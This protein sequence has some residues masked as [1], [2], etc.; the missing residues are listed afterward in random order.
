MTTFRDDKGVPGGWG[1]YFAA[2]NGLSL[3]MQSGKYRNY[4]EVLAAVN[5]LS[6]TTDSKYTALAALITEHINNQN[7]ID[8]KLSSLDIDK[9]LVDNFGTATVSQ[10]D[11]NDL[12]TTPANAA[13]YID[14]IP[15][16]KTTDTI[17]KQ[18]LNPISTYGD[19]TWLPV[20]V[21]NDY[22]GATSVSA[23][24]PEVNMV[25]DNSTYM[26]IHAGTNGV[27]RGLYFHRLV[28]VIRRDDT[29]AVM[30]MH[31]KYTP[32]GLTVG[33]ATSVISTDGNCIVG[34]ITDG[35][36][37]GFVAIVNGDMNPAL[38]KTSFITLPFDESRDVFST[39]CVAGD[40]V[41]VFCG[42][43]TTSGNKTHEV[44][45][46]YEFLVYRIQISTMVDGGSATVEQ[47]TGW[48]VIGFHDVYN[49]DG[50]RLADCLV[51]ADVA[52]NPLMVHRGTSWLNM[53]DPL[54]CNM[55]IHAEVNPDNADEI[56]LGIHH[57]AKATTISGE[58]AYGFMAYSVLLTVG[59]TFAATLEED[60]AG[61]LVVNSGV[62][63]AIVLSSDSMVSPHNVTGVG[64]FA[65]WANTCMSRA[66]YVLTRYNDL[67]KNGNATY[68]KSA[69]VGF[70][71][72]F[73]A[74]RYKTLSLHTEVTSTIAVDTETDFTTNMVNPRSLPGNYVMMNGQ[75]RSYANQGSYSRA[76]RVTIT[77]TPTVSYP[78]VNSGN[79]LGWTNSLGTSDYNVNRV[80]NQCI[81]ISRT[82]AA[83]TTVVTNASVMYR[84]GKGGG[85]SID[86]DGVISGT[87]VYDVNEIENVVY[88]ALSLITTR[89]DIF[90]YDW[91]AYVPQDAAL[92]IAVVA[93]YTLPNG[94]GY[95]GGHVL[96]ELEHSG[97]RADTFTGYTYKKLCK[98]VTYGNT[99]KDVWLDVESMG[100]CHHY[101]TT[102]SDQ[103]SAIGCP[104]VI[105]GLSND[106][107]IIGQRRDI[108]I[109]FLAAV[110]STNMG[111]YENETIR[112][113]THD[114][115]PGGATPSGI[116]NST[117]GLGLVNY[118]VNN[119]NYNTL[120]LVN[121][122]AFTYAQFVT[123]NVI[124]SYVMNA[125]KKTTTNTFKFYCDEPVF[126]AGRSYTVAKRILSLSSVTSTPNGKVFYVGLLLDGGVVGYDLSLTAQDSSVYYMAL[127][128]IA[129]SSA[130]VLTFDLRK[131]IRVSNY[132]MQTYRHGS[133]IPHTVGSAADVGKFHWL[134]E[135]FNG[136]TF[137]YYD[138]NGTA[139]SS[140]DTT[141]NIAYIMMNYD[142][143]AAIS[144][145][146]VTIEE[147]TGSDDDYFL[148]KL[149]GTAWAAK[150]IKYVSNS[151][152][153]NG[154]TRIN[155]SV[156]DN[157]ATARRLTTKLKVTITF[158][159]VQ[160]ITHT[161]TL[162]YTL[163]AKTG[164]MTK[165]IAS[166]TLQ[167]NAAARI[168]FG[169]GGNGFAWNLAPIQHGG[170][171][172]PTGSAPRGISINMPLPYDNPQEVTVTT[173]LNDDPDNPSQYLFQRAGYAS[174]SNV[175]SCAL[176]MDVG[177]NIYA[178]VIT[179][180]PANGLPWFN[181]AGPII[182]LTNAGSTAEDFRLL[183]GNMIGV[184]PIASTRALDTWTL[185]HTPPWYYDDQRIF[186]FGM[187]IDASGYFDIDFK[188]GAVT[189]AVNNDR[190][191][192]TTNVVYYPSGEVWT[193]GIRGTGWED[194][195]HY[196]TAT[197]IYPDLAFANVTTIPDLSIRLGETRGRNHCY[198]QRQP[199]PANNYVARVWLYDYDDSS[200]FYS[201]NVYLTATNREY[202]G[203]LRYVGVSLLS[204]VKGPVV[205]HP[206]DSVWNLKF[207]NNSTKNI[208]NMSVEIMLSPSTPADLSNLTF[209]TNRAPAGSDTVYSV[210]TT[211]TVTVSVNA[212]ATV[213]VPVEVYGNSVVV[214]G[215]ERYSEYDVNAYMSATM[216]YLGEQVVAATDDYHVE[217]YD[218][219]THTEVL[220]VNASIVDG[221]TTSWTFNVFNDKVNIDSAV[222]TYTYAISP[223][224]SPNNTL[225][226]SQN[227][228]GAGIGQTWYEV[229]QS[230]NVTAS[231]IDADG[232]DQTIRLYGNG[233]GAVS[234]GP[235]IYEPYAYNGSVV[236]S[237]SITIDGKTK[238]FDNL[239]VITVDTTD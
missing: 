96:F 152:P 63:T 181:N 221:A 146:T 166:G 71:T 150:T 201:T 12:F 114:C 20:N 161:D 226:F 24:S 89:S 165:H 134:S 72:K 16:F 105:R 186:S 77:G 220:M 11:I 169:G 149:P 39:A 239:G 131:P 136:I 222:I 29:T 59:D 183:V 175:T 145:V 22:A 47:V 191:G 174:V 185:E 162:G 43:V 108:G 3:M 27:T 198:V 40:Y 231:N 210:V 2:V 75:G 106:P 172:F 119:A 171:G 1:E 36:T 232:V 167:P 30:N 142:L 64:K 156:Y 211:K 203:A 102:E 15:E 129:V 82:S 193:P 132:E 110:R 177:T 69:I 206:N 56:R 120:M 21:T 6:T 158:G 49:G 153:V 184:T 44:T 138:T 176:N 112:T 127:G 19:K 41:Y 147:H 88:N 230:I 214:D 91:V 128:T 148:F 130:G 194:Y 66:G 208:T 81:F 26:G 38:H 121:S 116:A 55:R 109:I 94:N 154:S 144:N 97:S 23:H 223:D 34:R 87:F 126:M 9:G 235:V 46:P 42:P 101:L 189:I 229:Q 157:F 180:N 7:N 234:G 202:A 76:K 61:H 14:T 139:H 151:I 92:P 124:N 54:N 79:L 196:V 73:A 60:G 13:T 199:T 173:P 115:Y 159:G 50:I 133:G 170:D 113:L 188:T 107:S 225:T 178:K 8:H 32:K 74:L 100:G 68:A 197:K 78:T 218:P 164:A 48:D 217:Y 51:S 200:A 233:Q 90:Q 67:I 70:T 58:E 33:N 62:A 17:H 53:L 52:N 228:T 187:A 224:T 85:I 25:E 37:N 83:N 190:R 123:G 236:M 182:E 95:S 192:Y 18:G 31:H 28:D 219:L 117:I 45:T 212:G 215:V 213:I 227:T 104:V 209:S 237:A 205:I 204:I 195:G 57:T 103:L 80:F 10:T 155:V 122:M 168:K 143:N 118:T 4:E 207:V 163:T 238:V 179:P 216:T 86:Q 140:Y 111:T 84:G 98:H 135:A 99:G 125:Q 93:G 137:T 160:Y 35:S 5:E 141:Y 65:G